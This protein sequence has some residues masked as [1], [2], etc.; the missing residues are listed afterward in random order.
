[1]EEFCRSVED[2]QIS[3]Q[4]LREIRGSGAFRRFRET[5]A[6]IGMEQAWFQFRASALER[7]AVEW[8]EENQIAYSRDTNSEDPVN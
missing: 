4:L 2:P 1:M 6:I 5:I 8:L 3:E 7:I